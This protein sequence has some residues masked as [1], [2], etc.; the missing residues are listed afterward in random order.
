MV[1][2]PEGGG[3]PGVGGSYHHQTI[4]NPIL[5][6]RR[7]RSHR[8]G[9]YTHKTI[10]NPILLLYGPEASEPARQER[11]S[12]T[13]L[14]RTAATVLVPAIRRLRS[15]SRCLATFRSRALSSGQ[16][17]PSSLVSSALKQSSKRGIHAEPC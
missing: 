10:E 17:S 6:A 16:F 3:V 15:S 8:A 9:G 14:N 1:M 5:P 13:D 4:G 7:L 11:R 2:G 12:W